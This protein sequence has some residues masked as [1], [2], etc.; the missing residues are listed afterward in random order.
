MSRTCYL[1]GHNEEITDFY[2]VGREIDTYRSPDELVDKTRFYL[3]HSEAAERLR[4]AGYRR[5]IRDHT[6]GR[7]FEVLFRKIGLS[8]DR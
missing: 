2:D 4:E 1:T 7:R 6:W 8:D 5:A 3:A